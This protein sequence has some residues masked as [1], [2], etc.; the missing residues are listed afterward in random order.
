MPNETESLL[1]KISAKLDVLIRLTGI[2]I[3]DQLSV[4]ERAPLLARAGL[5]R[6]AIAAIC[7]TTPAAVS[8]RLA[9]SK[10]GAKAKRARSNKG[11]RS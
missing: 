5:D 3:G 9:E 1:I 7:N 11:G 8:V 4:A 6:N 2:A 10:R